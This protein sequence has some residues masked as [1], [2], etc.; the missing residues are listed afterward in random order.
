VSERTILLG[1]E[2]E[3]GRPV[4]IPVRHMAVTGITQESGKTTTLE[5]LIGRSGLR[6]VTFIT[7]RGESA[8]HSAQRI[9]PYFCAQWSWQ[10]VE[11][12]LEAY[13]DEPC[14]KLRFYLMQAC[15]EA[16][17]LADV[18]ENADKAIRT[19][20]N[21]SDGRAYYM[22][23]QYL[24]EILRDI[25]KLPPSNGLTLQPG[26]NACDI[27]EY[28]LHLQGLVISSVM[29][30]IAEREREV[31]TLVP[32]AWEFLP[33]QHGSPCKDA[34]VKLARKGACLDNFLWLDS[35]D[36][37]S[38]DI[39]IRKQLTVYLLGVQA[40]V[41]EVKRTLAHIPNDGRRPSA[42]EVMQLSKGWFYA[43]YDRELFCVYVQPAWLD[44]D[45]LRARRY[46]TELL[47]ASFVARPSHAT[48]AIVRSNKK[49]V[50]V[51]TARAEA[52]P[53]KTESVQ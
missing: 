7:K 32:E 45:P 46:A 42:A 31:I 21:G 48:M 20:D 30:W 38:I 25:A 13:L 37:A 11:S 51:N 6:A 10:Y 18:A 33:R 29:E 36:L 26:I 41:N 47:P 1:Y 9:P 40:E 39:Q 4:S 50:D 22:I 43:K 19:A 44:V 2:L 52:A 27:S 8:F 35:Q 23:G 53:A 49:R 3:T 16:K 28:P 34:A 15:A 5:A 12:L 17:S 14:G 24:S